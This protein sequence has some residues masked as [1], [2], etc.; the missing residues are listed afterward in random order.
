LLA[1]VDATEMPHA[2]HFAACLEV[3]AKRSGFDS[4]IPFVGYVG[5]EIYEVHRNG[6]SEDRGLPSTLPLATWESYSELSEDQCRYVSTVIEHL[7][8]PPEHFMAFG[9]VLSGQDVNLGEEGF[10]GPDNI[11]TPIDWAYYNL[12]F[13][14]YLDTGSAGGNVEAA[15]A[16]YSAL[17][18]AQEKVLEADWDSDAKTAL[19]TKLNHLMNFL[20]HFRGPLYAEF[21][22]TLVAYG[23][24]VKSARKRLDGIMA[25]ADAAMC[26][27]DSDV[28]IDPAKAL[29]TLL[30]LAGFIPALPYAITFGIGVAAV[31]VSALEKES[32]AKAT[33]EE[34]TIP[35]NRSHSCVDILRWYLD[36][37]RAT[38][39]Q[40]ADGTKSLSERLPALIGDVKAAAKD[41]HIP[42]ELGALLP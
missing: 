3:L 34:V 23:A 37:A 32:G 20:L 17:N 31:V 21:G 9:Q 22:A 13:D 33:P 19:A 35:G 41:V 40:L 1:G 4:P 27:L 25:Q 18:S 30:V 29:S 10:V 42:G 8:A 36:E 15:L 2:K 6:H 14:Q 5:Q 24:L 12:A 26:R 39:E 16:D 28:E 38:C 11:N 7:G